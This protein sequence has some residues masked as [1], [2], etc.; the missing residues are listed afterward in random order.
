MKGSPMRWRYASILAA[1]LLA[2][3]TTVPP[4]D[5]PEP[6]DRIGPAGTRGIGD[7]P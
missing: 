6:S 2:A 1:F 5:R 7:V 3:C 4:E